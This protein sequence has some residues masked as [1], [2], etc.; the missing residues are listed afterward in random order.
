[1]KHLGNLIKN[2]IE[3]NKLVKKKVSETVGI[4]A[5]YLSS[6]FNESTMDCSLYERICNAIGM[7]PT[8]A[9]DGSAGVTKNFSDISAQTIVG[10]ATVSIGETKALQDLLAE[11]ERLIQVLL[12][13]SGIK[14]DT[15]STL[16]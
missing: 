16:K 6:L 1:M 10:P 11:K 7:D 14:I 9:F 5:S 15:A 13:A 8:I 4:S 2:H 3:D 12:S